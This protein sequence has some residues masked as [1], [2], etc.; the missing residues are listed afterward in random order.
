MAP[1]IEE[2]DT[3]VTGA[4]YKVHNGTVTYNGK[5]YK[6]GSIFKAV[7]GGGDIEIPSGTT[8][9]YSL[10]LPVELRSVCAID[11]NAEFKTKHLEHGDEPLEYFLWDQASG[12]LPRNDLGTLEAG[13]IGGIR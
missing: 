2:D 9:I 11:L 6:A 8:A 13:F 4:W 7:S 12:Y 3:P 10:E 5:T 1:L